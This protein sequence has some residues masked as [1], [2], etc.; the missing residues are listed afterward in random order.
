MIFIDL[1]TT[2]LLKP[3]AT[4]IK[5]QPYITEL[6]VI[7]TTSNFEMIDE[8]ETFIKPPVPIPEVCVKITGITDEMVSAAPEFIEVF[9]EL[10]EFFLGEDIA[11][12][13]NASFDLGVLKYE[14]RRH[15]LEYNF[16]WPIKHHCTV[17][18]SRCIRNAR[19]KL[20]DLHQ[21]ATGKPHIE[22]A[23]RAKHDVYALIRCYEWLRKE[24]FVK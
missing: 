17:E 2:G 4:D 14:L 3:D 9:D 12:A 11:I 19:L 6:C 10:A 21:L 7:K 8:I 1:E 24:G 15:G 22:G 18:L 13:H 23:H 16:P 5:F 20:S